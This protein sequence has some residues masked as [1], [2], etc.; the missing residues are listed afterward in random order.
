MVF[1]HNY[2][3]VLLSRNSNVVLDWGFTQFWFLPEEP[4][5]A[6]ESQQFNHITSSIVPIQLNSCYMNKKLSYQIPHFT[7]FAIRI[8][9]LQLDAKSSVVEHDSSNPEWG[10]KYYKASITAQGLPEP[11]SLRVSTLGT[12]AAELTNWG[13]QIDWWLQSRAVFGH[14]FSGI[15][16]HMPQKWSQFNCMTL[17][18]WLAMR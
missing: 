7:G 13:M 4:S 11:S 15:I 14:T 2:E 3:D 16:L 12:I 5:S 17:S 10:P 6:I 1:V 8:Q 18:W 9:E